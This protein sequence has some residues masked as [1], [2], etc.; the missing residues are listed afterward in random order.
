MLA[1]MVN[2]LPLMA[3]GE[4]EVEG[5]EGWWRGR[6]T[7]LWVNDIKDLED[8]DYFPDNPEDIVADVAKVLVLEVGPLRALT[9]GDIT[10]EV[11]VGLFIISCE[12]ERNITLGQLPLDKRLV[13]IAFAEGKVD[14]ESLYHRKAVDFFAS[15]KDRRQELEYAA[16]AARHNEDDEDG[17][18]NCFY[19]LLSLARGEEGTAEDKELARRLLSAPPPLATEA[20]WADDDG[21]EEEGEA[22]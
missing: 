4:A 1:L 15:L 18:R 7:Q 16:K 17:D 21:D 8:L 11:A 22:S 2:V 3:A 10:E 6:L 13:L 19:F 5:S 20:H 12:L 14:P 9:A